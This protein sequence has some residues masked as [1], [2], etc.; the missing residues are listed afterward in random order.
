LIKVKGLNVLCSHKRNIEGVIDENLRELKLQRTLKKKNLEMVNLSIE[1][2]DGKV[3][4]IEDDMRKLK[5]F[6]DGFRKELDELRGRIIRNFGYEM[7]GKERKLVDKFAREVDK[8][9]SK[10]IDYDAIPDEVSFILKSC[11]D[12]LTGE[13]S[14]LWDTL[15]K[16]IKDA[17]NELYQK[18]F[19]KE[20]IP[21]SLKQIFPAN[22]II[23]NIQAKISSEKE[24]LL[25]SFYSRVREYKNENRSWLRSIFSFLGVDKGNRSQLLSRTKKEGAELLEDIVKKLIKAIEDKLIKELYET[26]NPILQVVN[27]QLMK[28]KRNLEDLKQNIKDKKNL[29]ERLNREI[30]ELEEKIR[31]IEEMKKELMSDL[32]L[33]C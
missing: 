4:K 9:R 28:E 15:F 23:V 10:S 26:F 5:V 32:H 16:D 25:R 2:I 12:E 31:R 22:T 17:T 30:K 29:T 13:D 3:K 8:C 18:V 11:I 27:E 7:R 19:E 1:E 24:G 14:K 20:F 33:E 21:S 6:S